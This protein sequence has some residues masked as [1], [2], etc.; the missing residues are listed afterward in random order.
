MMIH[1]YQDHLRKQSLLQTPTGYSA[2]Q[3]SVAC[4]LRLYASSFIDV[5]ANSRR[6]PRTINSSLKC[7]LNEKIFY[8]TRTPSFTGLW[9]LLTTNS[10]PTDNLLECTLLHGLLRFMLAAIKHLSGVC[11]LDAHLPPLM[12]STLPEPQ[13]CQRVRA[14]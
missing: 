4:S 6:S 9:A 5:D 11:L 14:A 7:H 13:G 8:L 3:K 10:F 2:Q 1:L 12:K